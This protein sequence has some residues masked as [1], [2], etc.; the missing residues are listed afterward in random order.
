FAWRTFLLPGK[1]RIKTSGKPPTT[2]PWKPGTKFFPENLGMK[3]YVHILITRIRPFAE[4]S[5]PL[6]ALILMRQNLKM[7]LLPS[8]GLMEFLCPLLRLKVFISSD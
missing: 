1:C 3:L 2:V 8:Q 7:K 5:C 4:E 6:L